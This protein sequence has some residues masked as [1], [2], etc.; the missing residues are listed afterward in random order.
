MEE[1]CLMHMTSF[2]KI[3]ELLSDGYIY[4]LEQI[5]KNGKNIDDYMENSF[6]VTPFVYLTLMKKKN[7]PILESFNKSFVYNAYI[8]LILDSK[9]LLE[10][11]FYINEIWSGGPTGYLIDGKKNENLV[12][13][14]EPF[15]NYLK[16]EVLIEKKISLKKYLR[17]VHISSITT[18]YFDINN[19]INTVFK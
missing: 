8:Y 10:N 1:Y 19:I 2:T 5:I 4:S 3:N 9:I 7:I 18:S 6:H 14:I 12:K 13:I 15:S 17:Q 16:N 11:K